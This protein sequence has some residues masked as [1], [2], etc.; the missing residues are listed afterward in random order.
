MPTRR[1]TEKYWEA[2]QFEKLRTA[3]PGKLYSK[4]PLPWRLLAYLLEI[5]PDVERLRSVVRK[6][7]MEFAIE[8]GQKQLMRMLMTLWGGGFV[9]LEP[10]PPPSEVPRPR[11]AAWLRR[12]AR[13]R[14]LPHRP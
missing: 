1:K 6:R 8:A 11:A 9:R 12:P 4:G 7:L 13:Q 3:P 5:S 10:E 2:V 14:L